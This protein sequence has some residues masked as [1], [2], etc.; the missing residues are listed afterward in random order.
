MVVTKKM[1]RRDGDGML[2]L[3]AVLALNAVIVEVQPE[4]ASMGRPHLEPLMDANNR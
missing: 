2:A 1:G 4:I 3:L